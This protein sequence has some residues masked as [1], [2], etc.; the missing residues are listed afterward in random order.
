[1]HVLDLV[2]VLSVTVLVLVL[3][4]NVLVLVL[5][6]TVLVLKCKIVR[7][8]DFFHY[9]TTINLQTFQRISVTKV[10]CTDNFTF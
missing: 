7:T 4:L 2:L 1:M 5:S 10:P 6:H 8:C 3:S 9:L